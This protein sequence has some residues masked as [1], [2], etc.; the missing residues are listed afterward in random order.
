MSINYTISCVPGWYRVKDPAREPPAEFCRASR[1]PNKSRHERYAGCRT[2]VDYIYM[3]A[4]IYHIITRVLLYLFG[5]G[6]K[7]RTERGEQVREIKNVL[8]M[9]SARDKRATYI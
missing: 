9:I 3:L 2:Y 8:H 4:D 6:K 1:G 7:E 5:E